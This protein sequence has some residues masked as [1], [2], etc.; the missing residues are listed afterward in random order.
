MRTDLIEIIRRLSSP[1]DPEP[2]GVAPCLHA[3]LDIRAVL[4]D[5]YGTLLISG[6]GDVGVAA[7]MDAPGALVDAAAACGLELAPDPM[8]TAGNLVDAFRRTVG[9]FHAAARQSGVECPEVDIREVWARALSR[10]QADWSTTTGGR[11]VDVE[12]LAVEYECRVNP[13]WEM[14]GAGA[15]LT[16]LAHRGVPV[17]IVSNAQFLT[18]M[19][20]PAL[21][22]KTLEELGFPDQYCSFSYRVSS[23][24]PAPAIFEGPLAHLSK[25]HGISQNKVIY[26]GNDMLNDVY[27]AS[28]VGCRTCLFAGDGR[29]LRRR[30]GDPRAAGL[31]PDA[32]ITQLKHLEAFT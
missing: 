31:E 1:R 2:T 22:G 11:Q 16:G 14:P 5:I 28:R 19:L 15:L 26:V 3:D 24:K 32:T 18:P 20:F 21:L 9:D 13:V 29:S 30:S 12:R 10:R 25:D 8:E 4:F 6:S 27:G 23:S 7:A 17:G